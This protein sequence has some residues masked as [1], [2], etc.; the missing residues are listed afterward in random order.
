MFVTSQ[1]V[2]RVTLGDGNKPQKLFNGARY[3]HLGSE[4]TFGTLYLNMGLL[5]LDTTIT[6]WLYRGDQLSANAQQW[7]NALASYVVFLLPIVLLVLITRSYQDRITSA[8]VFVTAVVSWQVLS[9]GIGSFL[10]GQYGFRDRP[11][12][13]R[14]LTE[15]FLERPEK[16]FPSDH[17]AVLMA[18]TIAFFAYRYP[19]LGWLFLVLGVLSSIA[20]VAVGF[21]WAGDVLAG[22]VVAVIAFL[23]IKAV[24]RPL[25]NL[26]DRVLTLLRLKS[27]AD[28]QR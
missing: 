4:A 2:W 24:D 9:F 15:L 28:L 22:W 8:K 7:L 23:I 6:F 11:F 14:G 25:T 26:I 1:G 13:E 10:Y 5:E 3:S 27:K 19:K 17:A 20:R 18:V 16:A 12:T 21:H